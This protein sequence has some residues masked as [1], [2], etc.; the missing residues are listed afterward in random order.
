MATPGFSAVYSIY[1]SLSY[2]DAVFGGSSGLAQSADVLLALP[3]GGVRNGG[4]N[5]GGN[6]GCHVACTSCDAN[7]RR[8]CTNSC[9]GRSITSSCCLS[10]FSCQSGKC[11]CASP[12]TTCGGICTDTTTDPSNCGQ[13]GVVCPP[14]GTCQQGECFPKPMHCGP[15]TPGPSG[16]TQTCCQQVSPDQNLCGVSSCQLP[17]PTCQTF[18]GMCTGAGGADQCVS[19]GGI[20]QCCHSN[21]FYGWWPWIR[22]CS[23]GSFTQ[24]C[25]GPCWS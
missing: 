3:R 7:C 6:G 9:T 16:G 8:T 24:G 2:S 19:A 4:G 13:C 14:G 23:D 17:P 25:S 18:N 15:C 5:G 11:I 10:G 1:S 12:K 21:W 20:T 22:I